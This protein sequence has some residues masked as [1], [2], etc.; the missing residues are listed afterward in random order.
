[1]QGAVA[2]GGGPM[3]H[4]ELTGLVLACIVVGGAVG[5]WVWMLVTNLW[6]GRMTWP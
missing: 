2:Y 4:D 5:L 1:V 6:F 3:K